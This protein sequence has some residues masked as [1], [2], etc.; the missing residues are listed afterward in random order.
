[1]LSQARR[2]ALAAR[3]RAVVEPWAAQAWL[4]MMMTMP[5]HCRPHPEMEAVPA[6]VLVAVVRVTMGG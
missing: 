5:R 3:R 1:M 2:R 4:L 6:A